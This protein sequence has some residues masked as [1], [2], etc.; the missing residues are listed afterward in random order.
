M[1]G[2]TFSWAAWTRT[3]ALLSMAYHHVLSPLQGRPCD[4][5]LRSDQGRSERHFDV[6]LTSTLAL[7]P[8]TADASA[9]L[10]Q[11]DASTHLAE[12]A[13]GTTGNLFQ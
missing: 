11:C 5:A 4:S 1:Q 12:P 9:P 13:E 3:V 2:K 6:K 8:L 7:E 10:R